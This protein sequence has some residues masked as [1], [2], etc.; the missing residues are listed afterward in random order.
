MAQYVVKQGD[1][2][3][4]IAARHGFADYRTIYNHPSNA[5]FKAARP[6]PN[7][8]YPG[9]VLVIPDKQ[10]KAV[11]VATGLS[12]R[13]QVKR[14]KARFRVRFQF[15]VSC[16][17][18]VDIEG[19]RSTGTLDDGAILDVP[20]APEAST[21]KLL[22]WPSSAVGD[23]PLEYD[24]ILG[25]LDPIDTTSGV[26]ARLKN[27]GFECGTVDGV[28]GSKTKR[29]VR[30]FQ[31]ASRLDVTGEIDDATR[32]ALTTRHDI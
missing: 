3:S 6:N 5:D 21:G 22:I 14:A 13:F 31:Q 23:A 25:A 19:R 16:K 17:Y 10:S 2:L 28:V 30:A 9:D 27:L 20:I 24:L 11:S 15:G 32:Q 18:E 29:A 4:S 12:H 26:Q 7:V 8:L 1:C